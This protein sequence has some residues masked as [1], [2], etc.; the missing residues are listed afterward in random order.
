MKDVP[1]VIFVGDE[2]HPKKIIRL[3]QGRFASCDDTTT[4][5]HESF[6]YSLKT[7]RILLGFILLLIVALVTSTAFVVLGLT[8]NKSTTT[9]SAAG[10]SGGLSPPLSLTY[11][12][13]PSPTE[14]ILTLAP[15]VASTEAPV[16]ET[17]TLAPVVASTEPPVT[18]PVVAFT[19]A[20]VTET[21]TLA[22]VVASTEPP[23]TA[24]VVAS[25][26][27]PVTETETITFAPVMASTEA[28][29]TKMIEM[30]VPAPTDAPKRPPVEVPAVSPTFEPDATVEPPVSEPTPEDPNAP[31]EASIQVDKSTYTLGESIVI[32][33]ENNVTQTSDWIAMQDVTDG[34][35]DSTWTAVLWVWTCGTQTCMDSPTSGTVI[36]GQEGVDEGEFDLLGPGKYVMHLLRGTGS[37]NSFAESPEFTIV[38]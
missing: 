9:E 5:G 29:V 6:I 8:K 22:P 2:D 12:P 32:I 10:I 36:F 1:S 17:I 20:P 34:A 3:R 11:S 13:S 23:V 35:T 27:A 4:I 19:E 7:R 18:A 33:F 16:T 24:P 30:P 28:P 15:V 14:L 21:I 37:Y 25:T 26:E 38:Q 31:V